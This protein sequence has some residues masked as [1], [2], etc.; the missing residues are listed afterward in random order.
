MSGYV[1]SDDVIQEVC[2][3]LGI[4]DG[5][6]IEGLSVFLKYGLPVWA[7]LSFYLPRPDGGKEM[8]I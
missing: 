3:V 2:K 4:Q 7:E 8:P 1:M 5:G 6:N